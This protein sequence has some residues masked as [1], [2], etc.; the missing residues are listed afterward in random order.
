MDLV[1]LN[2]A[3][4]VENFIHRVGKHCESSSLR[5]MFEYYGYPMSEEMVFGLDA[6]FGFG[7]FDKS[8]QFTDIVE[9]NIPFFLGGKQNIISPD[10]LACRILGVSLRKQSFTST[11]KAWEESKIL[12]DNNVPLLVQC[13]LKYLNYFDFENEIHFGG[14]FVALG[15]YD[16][17]RSVAFVADTEFEGLQEISIERLKIARSSEHGPPF[18][19]PKNIQYSMSVK[20]KHPPLSAGIKLAIQQVCTNMLRASL[21]NNG[22]QGLKMFANS[23]SDWKEDLEGIIISPYNGKDVNLAQLMFELTYGYIE[24]WGTGGSCFRKLYLDF[25]K[26][27]QEHPELRSGPKPWSQHDFDILYEVIPLLE[28]VV[29]YWKSFADSLK[30]EVDEYKEDCL[31]HVNLDDIQ[32]KVQKI[33]HKE[34]EIFTKL[35]KIKI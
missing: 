7:F 5:D 12:I 28:T 14:H 19:R 1:S 8:N 10:S 30:Q 3:H 16:E 15:G 35:S 34:E 25:L 29:F 23:I 22:I 21:S 20:E 27:L 6:T 2:K 18:L 4:I 17:E 33:V 9:D 11:D 32:R 26:E 24:E 31:E 13:D